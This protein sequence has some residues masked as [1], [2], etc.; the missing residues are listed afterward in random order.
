MF[1]H[2]GSTVVSAMRNLTVGV[3]ENLDITSPMDMDKRVAYMQ[4]ILIGA[5]LK[6]Y[7]EVL[8]S[9][10]NLAKELVVDKWNLRKLTGLSAE[11]F[12]TWANTDTTG[13]YVHAYLALD[14]CVNFERGVWFDFLK[15]MW[16]NHWSVYQ[17]HMKYILNDTLKPFRV[18]ILRYDERVRE[19]H[20]LATL[21]LL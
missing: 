10:S 11:A 9:C 3:F 19:M 15:Y 1:D 2:E 12:W 20:D 17:D 4:R 14:Q 6:N 16:I 13:C 21:H 8:V 7:R 5:A 18:K